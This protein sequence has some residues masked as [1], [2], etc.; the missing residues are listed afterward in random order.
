VTLSGGQRQRL[1]IARAFVKDAPV[2]ILDEPTSALDAEN[3]RAVLDAL[4]RLMKDR[5]TLI[6]AHRLS[7]IRAADR[8]IVLHEGAVVE[9]GTHSELLARGEVYARLHALQAGLH[10]AF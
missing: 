4:A 2:L 6:I 1:G 9:E 3:E 8:I 7:T 10:T 5:T